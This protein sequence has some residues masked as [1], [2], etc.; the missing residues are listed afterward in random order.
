MPDDVVAGVRLRRGGVAGEIRR[1]RTGI[2]FL[3]GLA[4]V[5][6][7]AQAIVGGGDLAAGPAPAPAQTP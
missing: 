4:L 7:A 2:R 6:F 1:K 3:G 5:L